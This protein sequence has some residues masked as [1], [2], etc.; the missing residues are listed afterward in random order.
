MKIGNYVRYE[1]VNTIKVA[2]II[3]IKKADDEDFCFLDNNDCTYCSLIKDVKEKLKDIIQVGDFITYRQ[4]NFYWEVPTRVTGRYNEECEITE[5]MVD[6]IPLST[7]EILSVV[8]REQFE[9][10]KYIVEEEKIIWHY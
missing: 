6:G 10:E 5:L 2:K 1:S 4:S 3:A 8:T 7:V 9:N